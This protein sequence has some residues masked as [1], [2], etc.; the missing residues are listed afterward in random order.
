M[1]SALAR[2]TGK[3]RGQ[4]YSP[5]FSALFEQLQA[6]ELGLGEAS[7]ILETQFLA[8][9][10]ELEALT[11]FGSGFVR[12]VETLVR[13]ATG[14]ECDETVF[15]NAIGMI[16]QATNF[17]VSCQEE[18]GQLLE[19]L[20]SYNSQIEFLLGVE[21]QLERTM[22]PLKFMQTLFKVESAPL[23]RGVQQMF[24]ALTEEIEGLHERVREI[25]GTKFKQLEETHRTIGNV[26]V[27]LDDR[28]RSLQATTAVQK[29]QI[30]TSLQ[31]L[32]K[33]MNSNQ[34]RDVRLSRLSKKL[35]S[36]VEQVVMGLQ[37]QDIVNQKIQH[38][39]AAL[40]EIKNKFATI[41]N[42]PS[43]AQARESLQYLHQSCRL[44]AGQVL[45]AQDDLR[46]AEC[47]IQAGIRK[48]LSQLTELDSQCLSLE[49]FQV[50]TT[51]FDGIVHVLL[52]LIEEVRN[53]VA[54]TVTSA[55]DAYEM[56][57]PLGTL[58]SDLTTI[59]RDISSRIHLIAI[60]S[61]VQAALAVQDHRGVALE[62]L[63]T[64][65]SEISGATNRISEEAAVQLDSLAAGLAGTVKA[66]EEL[67]AGGLKEQIVLN[68]QGRAEEKQLHSFRDRA[69]TTLCDIGNSLDNIRQQA[70]RTLA[71]LQFSDFHQVAL[72]AL[73]GPLD[74]IADMA[75][76]CLQL[77]GGETAEVCLIEN[78]KRDY[79]M[80]SERVVFAEVLSGKRLVE[81]SMAAAV[82]TPQS[83]IELF[84]DSPIEPTPA[85]VLPEGRES[86]ATAIIELPPG[87][88]GVELGVNVELF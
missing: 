54:A 48:V 19:M 10:A 5:Q 75:E 86:E 29:R 79:T 11:Q 34:E 65:T 17:L 9:G 88:A 57:R 70:Q 24:C 32:R 61:Q 33:E 78:F 21:A 85:A 12:E 51:S 22:L 87:G 67:R 30:E 52:D 62:V 80:A 40:P 8:I 60:N 66:F 38:V 41:Q 3:A 14:K 1:L 26:I 27:Q 77:Q 73:R 69:L 55:T 23:G 35:A 58:A 74:A 25:F 49:E 53:L 72:L 36:E 2:L 46:N 18:T 56:L 83:S 84:T 6:A 59:V 64:R 50:L 16:E 43:T 63:S 42:A 82:P 28:T 68:E 7:G 4:K 20:R 44:E 13:L 81:A 39:T 37:F 71:T 31:T 45:A 76:K 15:A 47:A